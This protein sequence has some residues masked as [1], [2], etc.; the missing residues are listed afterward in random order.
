MEE[1]MGSWTRSDLLIAHYSTSLHM[2]CFRHLARYSVDFLRIGHSDLI[3]SARAEVAIAIDIAE[4]TGSTPPC[5]HPAHVPHQ[6]EVYT[7]SPSIRVGTEYP[8][9]VFELRS[10]S[11]ASGGMAIPPTDSLTPL[12]HLDILP[13]NSPSIAVFYF[14]CR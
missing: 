13:S 1:V 6:S 14:G 8:C 12:T 4:Y 9:Q 3:P 2:V 7:V 11:A 10:N 5:H